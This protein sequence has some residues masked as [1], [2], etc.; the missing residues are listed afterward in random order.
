MSSW[1]SAYGRVTLLLLFLV[2]ALVFCFARS[3]VMSVLMYCTVRGERQEEVGHRFIMFEHDAENNFVPP[4]EYTN[5]KVKVP[6]TGQPCGAS[7]GQYL[8]NKG[9]AHGM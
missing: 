3:W 4:P 9:H 2:E 5:E 6:K 1:P 7:T 8:N